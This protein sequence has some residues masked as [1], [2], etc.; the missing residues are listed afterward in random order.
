MKIIYNT[1]FSKNIFHFT[2]NLESHLQLY[3]CNSM[4]VLG[5]AHTEFCVR[6]PIGFPEQ[7][8]LCYVKHRRPSGSGPT[9][10]SEAQIDMRGF[11]PPLHGSATNSVL[12]LIR[13]PQWSPEGLENTIGKCRDLVLSLWDKIDH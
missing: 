4:V 1:L 12:W 3:R 13:L 5:G 10:P 8:G 6:V 2:L 11:L 9:L 7:D